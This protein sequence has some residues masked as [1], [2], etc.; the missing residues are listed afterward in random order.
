[1]NALYNN[2]P[3]ISTSIFTFAPTGFLLNVIFSCVCLMSMTPKLRRASSTTVS[4]NDVPSMA[5]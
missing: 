3:T 5:T 2:L 1:M 4:V